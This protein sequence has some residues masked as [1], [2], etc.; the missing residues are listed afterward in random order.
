[1]SACDFI[2]TL[3]AKKE[4]AVSSI[5]LHR[6]TKSLPLKLSVKTSTNSGVTT[7]GRNCNTIFG[8]CV[9]MFFYIISELQIRYDRDKCKLWPGLHSLELGPS[10]APRITS[11]LQLR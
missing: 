3:I 6:S 2:E 8:V 1:M 10:I 11:I 5:S 9:C 4:Q 7:S